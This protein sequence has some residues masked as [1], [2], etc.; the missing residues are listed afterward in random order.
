MANLNR[1]LLIGRLTRD[2]ELRYTASGTPV[3]DFG[4]A[5]NRF[6]KNPDGSTQEE[7]TF[8]DI[9]TWSRTA[10]L[11]SQYLAKGRQVFVEGRLKF[12]Q[13]TSPEG[14]K[15]SKLTVVADNLQ[16]LDAKGSTPEGA[17]SGPGPAGG[18]SRGRAPAGRSNY[19]NVPEEFDSGPPYGEPDFGGSA[20]GGPASS[21]DAPF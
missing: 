15:R 6:R 3:A 4:L 9:T 18:A 12:D 20:G 14:Q 17:P 8:V 5:V 21:E 2:P 7:T 10:E 11:A 16:F 13:W 19:S 1:V